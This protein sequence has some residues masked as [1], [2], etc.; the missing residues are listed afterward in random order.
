MGEMTPAGLC[1]DLG[2]C[3]CGLLVSHG[4]WGARLLVGPLATKTEPISAPG[5]PTPDL[6]I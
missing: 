3:Y 2:Y 6:G 1:L 5:A 4:G